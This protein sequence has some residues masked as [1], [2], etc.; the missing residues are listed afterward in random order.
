MQQWCRC[1]YSLLRW[2]ESW[3][4]KRSSRVTTSTFPSPPMAMNCGQWPKEWDHR[5]KQGNDFLLRLSGLSARNRM[6]SL[7]IPERFSVSCKAS[8]EYRAVTPE[9]L[10]GRLVRGRPGLFYI[11]CCPT[12]RKAPQD[13]WMNGLMDGWTRKLYSAVFISFFWKVIVKNIYRSDCKN[14]KYAPPAS[15][16]ILDPVISLCISTCYTLKVFWCFLFLGFF[17]ILP[18]F[19]PQMLMSRLM[20]TLWQ[21]VLTL[22]GPHKDRNMRTQRIKDERGYIRGAD[23]LW[24]LFLHLPS[25]TKHRVSCVVVIMRYLR[26]TF[27]TWRHTWRTHTCAGF[28]PTVCVCVDKKGRKRGERVT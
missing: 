3:V 25:S 19:I 18:H 23:T 20:S 15:I 11:D 6:R 14:M 10:D 5:Y 16:Q 12:F 17:G 1:F 21:H 13:G 27:I 22:F 2:R 7:V 8:S 28:L 4:W 26:V 24:I 9:D